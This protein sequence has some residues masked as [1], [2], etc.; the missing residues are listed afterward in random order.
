MKWIMLIMLVLLVG[1]STDTFKVGV[2][3]PLSGN[4]AF[5]G[6]DFK[7][8]FSLDFDLDVVYQDSQ[9][10]VAGAVSAY[11]Q[12]RVEGVDVIVTVSSGD[13][14]I[15]ELADK[16]QIPLLLTVSSTGGLPE[17]SEWA[18]R[19]FTNADSDVPV[20][21]DYA[22]NELELENFGVLH[23]VDN[24]G[25]SYASVF[26]TEVSSLSGE[27]IGVESF[28]YTDYE[29]RTQ[30]LKL[31][32]LEVD[33]IYVIGLDYQVVEV[34]KEIEELDIEVQILSLGTIATDYAIGLAEGTAE[35]VYTTAFCTDGTPVEYK[36][37]FVSSYGR[38]PGFFS[39][40]GNDL[41][42]FIDIANEDGMVSKEEFVANMLA[43]E[44]VNANT[45]IVSSDE[46]GE[47]IM[48][49]CV[50]KIQD[51]KILNLETGRYYNEI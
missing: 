5:I 49:V 43:L 26:Q 20:L 45:G 28:Q 8:G 30:L 6:T 41:A 32:E 17:Q 9:G 21:V 34:L 4:Q 14:A 35:G 16:D 29:Y 10:N 42:M 11:H 23:L 40:L 46:N 1:C 36:Q 2:I 38:D 19:Y 47:L 15:I 50:K 37:R 31:A 44:N 13:E 25:Y 27:V 24:F 48:P 33:A 7:D 22:V 12:L 18:F 3:A 39:E 51:G